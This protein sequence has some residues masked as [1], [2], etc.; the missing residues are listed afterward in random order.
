M[1]VEAFLKLSGYNAYCKLKIRLK[2]FDSEEQDLTR[3]SNIQSFSSATLSR[4]LNAAPSLS[5]LLSPSVTLICF[6]TSQ[7]GSSAR[8][9]SPKLR[10][11]PPTSAKVEMLFSPYYKYQPS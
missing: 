9:Q 6:T 10:Y 1:I 4:S 2:E 11:T 8:A 3:T 7:P 5:N